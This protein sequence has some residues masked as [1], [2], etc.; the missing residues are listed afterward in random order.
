MSV[1]LEKPYVMKR[2]LFIF[3]I[4]LLTTTV[5]AQFKFGGGVTMGSKT[6]IDD[7]GSEKMGFGVN[8]RGE[9]SLLN[10]LAITPGFTYFFPSAPDGYDLSI[11]QAN[12]DVHYT[13]V[14][15]PG[16]VR[17]Y[18]LGGLNYTQVKTEIDL[19]DT[20]SY[21]DTMGEFA[22]FFGDAFSEVANYDDTDTDLGVNVG[23]GVALSKLYGEVKYDT[24]LEQVALSVGILF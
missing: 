9:F 6:G 23:A 19:G 20:D 8:V 3:L 14:G 5:S 12:A 15:S 13:L 17:L 1:H 4:G 10:K 24:A 7:D 16:P 11:W 22:D 2:V 18:A 21:E